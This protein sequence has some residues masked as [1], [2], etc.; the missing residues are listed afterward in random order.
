MH[1]TWWAVQVHNSSYS[2]SVR[3]LRALIRPHASLLAE[4]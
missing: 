4:L 3:P 2:C 1:G